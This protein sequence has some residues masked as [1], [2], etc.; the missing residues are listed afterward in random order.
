L[1][2]N[3]LQPRGVIAPETITELVDS[4]LEHGII[5]PIVVAHTPA[6]YQIIAGERRWRASKL[7][8]LQEVPCIVKEVTPKQ[9]LEMAIVENVQR[10]DLNPIERAKAFQRL[11]GEFQLS[12]DEA[13]KRIGK[14]KSFVANSVRLLN[15]PDAIKDGLLSEMIS[16]GH[17]RAL[18]G[19]KDTTQMLA[20][21][22]QVLKESA[23]VR[24]A[25][26]LIRRK[27]AEL[28]DVEYTP[29]VAPKPPVISH[30][31]LDQMQKDIAKVLG[32]KTKVKVAQTQRQTTVTITLKGR[33]EENREELDKIYYGLVTA[34]RL[35]ANYAET[36]HAET[37]ENPQS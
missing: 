6:G 37:E 21:Y 13:G 14:S 23:S 10:E 26:E 24:R 3:P 15:M 34:S 7:A 19:L 32:E 9:M 11:M 27:K 16:E 20:I 2:P 1:Q 17:A 31:M 22:K 12:I 33:A 36:D 29:F 28:K 5:E 25:E 35:E 30:E 4:I 18:L 8:K